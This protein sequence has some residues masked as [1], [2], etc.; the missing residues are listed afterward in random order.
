MSKFLTVFTLIAIF[1]SGTTIFAE[2]AVHQD[3]LQIPNTDLI[4]EYYSAQPEGSG[5]WPVLV[6]IHPHQ[7]WPNKIGAVVFVRNQSL[8]YWAKK[9]FL[10]FAVSQPGFGSDLAFKISAF[11]KER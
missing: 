7:E 6:M 11:H 4:I 8:D 5:P 3:F 9:G 1:I 10:T 2:T